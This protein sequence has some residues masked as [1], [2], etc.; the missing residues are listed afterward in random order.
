MGRVVRCLAHGAAVDSRAARTCGTSPVPYAVVGRSS[1]A[2]RGCGCWG[3]SAHLS[4]LAAF[5]A[6]WHPTHCPPGILGSS[7]LGFEISGEVRA[8][9]YAWSS[10]IAAHSQRYF[11][12]WSSAVCL[13]FA[14]VAGWLL[15]SLGLLC[16]LGFCVGMA[17]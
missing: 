13:V 11:S 3:R 14:D 9:G 12:L 8:S 5:A 10:W 15:L 4:G 6:F 1:G 17:G 7:A 16:G 2:Q